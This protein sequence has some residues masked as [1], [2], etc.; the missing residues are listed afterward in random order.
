MIVGI[1]LSAKPTN[2]TGICFI[3]GKE[4]K[5]LTLFTNDEIVNFCISYRPKIIAIDA[6]LGL[7]ERLCDKMMKKYGAMP[8]KLK[9]IYELGA[10]AID[11]LR[12]ITSGLKVKIIE[13]FP[14]ASA[15]ILGV[16]HKKPKLMLELMISKFL[17]DVQGKINKDEVD[18]F[19]AGITGLLYN[20]ELA[21]EVGDND[22]KIVIP[23][24]EK[25]VEIESMLCNFKIQRAS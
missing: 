7:G 20:N 1:D 6:P 2:R 3:I 22:G 17:F 25:I 19:L 23:D 18:S 9:P 5:V 11:L 8:L 4:A 24:V 16:Y 13:V 10:R 12:L 21:I 14:T 15:K